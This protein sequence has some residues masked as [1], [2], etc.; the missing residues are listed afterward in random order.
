MLQRRVPKEGACRADGASGAAARTA[1]AAR[2]LVGSTMTTKDPVDPTP[3]APR[4]TMA[5]DVVIVGAGPAGLAAACRLGLLAAESGEPRSI[6]VVEKGAEVGAHIVS[7]AIFD[8]RAL[9]ELFPDWRERGAPVEIEVRAE[10]V[11]WLLGPRR[12]VTVPRMLVPRP[13]RNDSG[14]VISLGELCRWLAV[15]A[16]ALGVDVLPGFAA[17]EVLYDAEGRV[18]GVATG[19]MGRARDG[20]PKPTFQRGYA[21]TAKYVIFAEGCR[22]QLAGELERCFD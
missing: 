13:L 9:E 1:A 3:A 5:F 7:G 4:E 21:L 6:C 17:T 16:E 8:P 2:R 10:R 15:E 12:S 22:G 18:A 19:D 11:E 20:T 14:Y